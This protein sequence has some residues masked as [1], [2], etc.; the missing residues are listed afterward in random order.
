MV[1]VGCVVIVYS[2]SK[3]IRVARSMRVRVVMMIM[4]IVFKAPGIFENV[5]FLVILIPGIGIAC[6]PKPE[7]REGSSVDWQFAPNFEITVL[8]SSTVCH[9]AIGIVY[10]A[11]EK[12]QAGHLCQPLH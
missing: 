8:E 9:L 5:D 11:R 1:V 12:E 7:S 4:I 3:A 6:I 10:L 2:C